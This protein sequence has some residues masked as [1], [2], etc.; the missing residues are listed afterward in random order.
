MEG[1]KDV[2]TVSGAISFSP[3]FHTVFGRDYRLIEVKNG[4]PAFQELVK[5][6]SP[7]DL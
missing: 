3:E 7:A 1:F 5:A 4:K 2:S 6:G